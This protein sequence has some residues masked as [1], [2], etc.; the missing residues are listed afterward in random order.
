VSY[1]IDDV[2]GTRSSSTGVVPNEKYSTLDGPRIMQS[3]NARV[4]PSK[5]PSV[6]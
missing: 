3:E 2:D 6:I 1:A 5:I 4:I